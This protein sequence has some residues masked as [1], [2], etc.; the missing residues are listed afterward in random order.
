MLM[1][2][3]LLL[4]AITK[5]KLDIHTSDAAAIKMDCSEQQMQVHRTLIQQ[6]FIIF[7]LRIFMSDAGDKQ[8]EV[9]EN[10]A[11]TQNTA[12]RNAYNIVQY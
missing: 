1:I 4:W 11:S 2:F 10:D 3:K 12:L 6:T 5:G 9:L 7:A 8:Y